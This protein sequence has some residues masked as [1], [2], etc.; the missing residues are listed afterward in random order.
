MCGVVVDVNDH[1][2]YQS[3]IKSL[4]SVDVKWELI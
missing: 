4:S 1:I 2:V 3:W